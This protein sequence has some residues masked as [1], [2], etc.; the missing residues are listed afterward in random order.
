MKTCNRKK[1]T[2]KFLSPCNLLELYYLPIYYQ[3]RED[4]I[5]SNLIN[6]RINIIMK[7]NDVQISLVRIEKRTKQSVH[8]VSKHKLPVLE[9]MLR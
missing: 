7:H 3:T 6:R 4:S 8:S 5:G 2:F 1:F 9:D